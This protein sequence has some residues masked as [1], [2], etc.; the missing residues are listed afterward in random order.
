MNNNKNLFSMS[1]IKTPIQI[2]SDIVTYIANSGTNRSDW[3]VGIATDPSD[4]LFIGHAVLKDSDLWI[5]RHA[6]TDT[7]ARTIEAHFINKLGTKGG[8][9]GGDYTSVYVYAYKI[10]S[11]TVE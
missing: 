11:H 2:V 3:Y 10:T 4:R 7:A 6:G 9:G 1:Q 8:P 5:F